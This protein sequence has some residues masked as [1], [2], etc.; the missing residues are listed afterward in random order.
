MNQLH[1]Q[2]VYFLKT[3]PARPDKGGAAHL[4]FFSSKMVFSNIFFRNNIFDESV[5]F[6]LYSQQE[7][8][9]NNTDAMWS[10]LTLDY[11]CYF[12]SS[13]QNQVILWR[14]GSVNGGGDYFIDDLKTYQVK[15]GK[16]THTIFAD[17]KLNY[18][19]TL[20]SDSPAINAGI[21]IGFPYSGN[22]PDIGAFEFIG[23]SKNPRVKK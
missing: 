18:D 22:A 15:S 1:L 8:S 20:Q 23:T 7:N 12:Q 14:G 17:P 19:Y 5:N 13:K 3:I 16:E 4:K 21:N 10:A 2:I 6:C 9:G 11:N